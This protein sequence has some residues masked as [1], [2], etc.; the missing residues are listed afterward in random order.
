MVVTDLKAF[1]EASI[2]VIDNFVRMHNAKML[3][4]GCIKNKA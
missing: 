1:V 2:P 4:M 3:C